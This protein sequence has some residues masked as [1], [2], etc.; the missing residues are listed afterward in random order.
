MKLKEKIF[1]VTDENGKYI[2]ISRKN[3]IQVLINESDIQYEE[4]FLCRQ[5][6]G[7][8]Q[9]WLGSQIL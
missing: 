6:K 5:Q 4:F 2:N 1:Q 8:R 3:N 7:F 9:R